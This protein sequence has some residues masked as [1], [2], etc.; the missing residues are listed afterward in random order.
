[1]HRAVAAVYLIDLLKIRTLIAYFR[2]FCL[3]H[4]FYLHICDIDLCLL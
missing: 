1:M 3:E 2:K 4:L